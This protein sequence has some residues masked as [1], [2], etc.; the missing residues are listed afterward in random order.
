MK[1]YQAL[2]LKLGNFHNW[3]GNFPV[4]SLLRHKENCAIALYWWE[5]NTMDSFAPILRPDPYIVLNT[6]ASLAG[7]GVSM[8]GSKTRGLFSSEESQH[9]I[10][11]LELKAALFGLKALCNNFHN[12][13]ILIQID[14]TS[15]VAAIN[16]MGSTRSINMDHV[17]HLTWNFILK[18]DN[19]IA[20]THIPGTFNEEAD[21]E[22]RK[23]ETRTEW[24]INQKYFQKIIK[25]SNFKPTV[26]LFATRLNTQLSHFISLR[27]DPESKGV[28]AFTL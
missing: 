2:T 4:A 11:I 6:D 12:I 14:N 5:S 24:M 20:A 9:H 23:H 28:N 8:A 15:T 13:H 27:P 25:S 19:R 22:S 26:D 3:P 7:W 17:V 1:Y 16:K 18:H 10:N 21:M